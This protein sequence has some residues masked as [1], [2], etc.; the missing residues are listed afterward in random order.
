M[1]AGLMYTSNPKQPGNK[2]PIKCDPIPKAQPIRTAMVWTETA[3]QD[4]VQHLWGG[5][6]FG[7]RQAASLGGGDRTPYLVLRSVFHPTSGR[8]CSVG[9]NM[10]DTNVTHPPGTSR[11]GMLKSFYL[12]HVWYCPHENC[13]GDAGALCS[14]P[15]G[16]GLGEGGETLVRQPSVFQDSQHNTEPHPD[17][18]QQRYPDATADWGTH[19]R[20]NPCYG[21]ANPSY[22]EEEEEEE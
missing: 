8:K 18:Q 3:F 16:L 19:G 2:V 12:Q 6:S 15:P 17:S 4:M 1:P 11:E 20:A 9:Q 21:Q 5:L 14:R 7:V 22:E 10:P 13:F